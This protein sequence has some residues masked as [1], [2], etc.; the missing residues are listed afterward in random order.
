MRKINLKP[1]NVEVQGQEPENIKIPREV[2]EDYLANSEDNLLEIPYGEV[3]KYFTNIRLK[4]IKKPYDIKESLIN[5]LFNRNLELQAREALDRDDLA[6]KIRDCKD[7]EIL[8]EENEFE[9]IKQGVNKVKGYTQND[10]EFI[11]RVLRCE[12]IEVEEKKK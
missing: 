4:T 5:V 10:V 9:K 12:R 1:Y 2:L 8:L 7:G 3:R 6:K 11:R